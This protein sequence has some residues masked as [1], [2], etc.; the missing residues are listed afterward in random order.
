M[1]PPRF[2]GKPSTLVHAEAGGEL[3]FGEQALGAEPR[4]VAGQLVAAARF[5]HDTGGERLALA[6][7]VT[8]GV[9]RL[10][11]LGVGV[12]VEEPVECGQGVGVGLAH[13]PGLGRDGDDE[14][15]GLPTAQAH[16]Q[17][18]AVG[19]SCAG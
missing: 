13:L 8:D 1:K 2:Q 19:R 10:G 15:G 16:V 4:G 3:G 17:V 5:E 12:G 14:A 9:E 18:D 7:V 6:G 11:G